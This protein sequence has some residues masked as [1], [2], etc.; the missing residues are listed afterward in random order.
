MPQ[1]VQLYY[2][3]YLILENNYKIM[4]YM[5]FVLAPSEPQNLEIVSATS[6]IVTL[7]WMPPKY[8]NGDIIRYAVHCDG[9]HI[10]AFGDHVSDKMIGSIDGLTPDTEYVIELTAYTRVGPGPPFSLPVKT[11]KLLKMVIHILASS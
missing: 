10:D 7:Q 5:Q 1:P 11:C 8:P 4:Y 9:K 3:V 2:K 6:T